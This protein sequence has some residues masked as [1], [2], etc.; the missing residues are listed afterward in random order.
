M[1]RICL[2]GN[3]VKDIELRY[4]RNNTGYVE[5]TIAVRKEKKDDDGN[6]GSDFITFVVFDK[7]AEYLNKYAKKGDRL[8]L[9]GKLRIDNWKDDKNEY[10]TKAYVVVDKINIS[11]SRIKTPQEETPV[12]EEVDPYKEFGESIEIDDSLLPF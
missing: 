4:T 11:T 9:E 3:M 6:Y 1:N 2:T 8:E 10:H 7:K 5:N 12:E